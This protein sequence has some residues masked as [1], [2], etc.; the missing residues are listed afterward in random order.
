MLTKGTLVRITA[1]EE[2]SPPSPHATTPLTA[3]HM[4]E[5]HGNLWL[6]DGPCLPRDSHVHYWYWC[7]SIATGKIY[8]WH[9][10]DFTVHAPA[11]KQEETH[12][13]T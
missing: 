4:L 2:G 7:K 10:T 3:N 8:D 5:L 9:V 12:H 11:E 1:G 6:I 13:A